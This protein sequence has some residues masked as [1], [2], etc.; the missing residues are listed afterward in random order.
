MKKSI[1]IIGGTFAFLVVAIF[2][3]SPVL[4]YQGDYTKEGPNC[5]PERHEAMTEAM[6]NNDYGVWSELMTG[7]GRVGKVVNAENFAQ[8]VEAR[9]LGQEGDVAGADAIRKEIGLRTSDG[10]K[11]GAGYGKGSG[12]NR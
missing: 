5:S 6:T 4:A 7:R 10:E 9:R 12:Q 8:F 3:L 2:A 11:L 1:K